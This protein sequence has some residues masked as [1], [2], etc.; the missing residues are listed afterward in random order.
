SSTRLVAHTN[1]VILYVNHL[2]AAVLLSFFAIFTHIT[3]WGSLIISPECDIKFSPVFCIVLNTPVHIFTHAVALS[4]LFLC[5][6]RL[7][8]TLFYRSY[9]SFRSRVY[10]IMVVVQYIICSLIFLYQIHTMNLQNRLSICSLVGSS[11]QHLTTHVQITIF[12]LELV[13]LAIFGIL[14]KYNKGQLRSTLGLSLIERYQ[15]DENVRSLRTI[16]PTICVHTACFFVPNAAALILFVIL[17]P[18]KSEVVLLLNWLPYYGLLLPL[19][20][21]LAGKK[22]RRA[23]EQMILMNVVTGSA[24]QNNYFNDLNHAWK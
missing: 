11:N 20:V 5:L 1:M 14:A 12:T 23:Q 2:V 7:L 4:L 19:V 21:H 8:A 17:Q 24:M 13:S 6:D 3:F 10:I 15:L 9:A 22:A 16:F 18:R